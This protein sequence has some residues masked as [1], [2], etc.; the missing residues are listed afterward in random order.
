[1]TEQALKIKRSNKLIK[2]FM[3]LVVVLQAVQ[4]YQTKVIDFGALAGAVGVLSLL[5]GILL[6][7]ILLVAPLRQWFQSNVSFSKASYKYF[8][9]ALILI[10]VSAF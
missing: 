9:L 10:L 6:S 5:R 7:P 4:F 8:L 2:G 3:A 1:M